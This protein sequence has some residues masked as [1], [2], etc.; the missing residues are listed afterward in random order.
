MALLRDLSIFW[1]MFHV[2]FLFIML[3][4]SRLTRKKTIIIAGTGM[5]VLMLLNGAGLILFG[6]ETLAKA[7]LFTCSIP[8]FLFF[9]VMSA[10]KRCRFLLTFCLA[11]TT[12]LWIMAVT[13]LLDHYL[14]GG[15]YVLLLVSRLVAFPLIEYC[16]WRFLRKPYL[17]LQDAVK[18]GWGIFAFMTMLYYVLLTVV[19]Q[20]PTNIVNRPEDTFLCILVLLL[21]FFN[22]STIFS[23]LYRQLLLYRKQQ[24]ERILQEQKNA[25]EKQLEDQQRIRRMKH[26]MKG[27][28]VT[29]SGLLAVGK[30][31]E[32]QGYLKGVAVEMD[33]L[34]G[35]FCAN[36]YLNAVFVHYYQKLQEMGA[37]CTLDI[38][39]GEEEL[40]YMELCQI[41]SNGLENVCD[42]LQGLESDRREMSVQMKYSR[43]YLVIRIRNRCRDSLYVEKGVIPVTGKQGQDHGFG[44]PTVQEAAERLGGGMSCYTEQGNFVLDV[45]VRTGGDSC[46]AGEI[47]VKGE[48]PRGKR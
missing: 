40:P 45:M 13:N 31:E 26:D 48:S 1:A 32:A 18:G 34:S 25:L 11:D 41:L 5:G 47:H 33:S 37:R 24:S 10:D 27:H 21:M 4:R 16:V 42:A 28:A 9:Y 2:I 20:F 12:C 43:A 38:Q 36:A 15:K 19:V 14:G 30:L 22:Y 7:F 23:A 29:L 8:S 44:L 6:F 35:P 46:F 17:E 39:V 3:F